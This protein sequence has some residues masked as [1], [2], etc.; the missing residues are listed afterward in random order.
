MITGSN[1]TKREEQSGDHHGAV[2]DRRVAKAEAIE[3][4]A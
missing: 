3:E 4:M 1:L 2:E